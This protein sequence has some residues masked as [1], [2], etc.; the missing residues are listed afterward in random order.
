MMQEMRC[1]GFTATDV[2]MKE[3]TEHPSASHLIHQAAFLQVPHHQPSV[4]SG[5]D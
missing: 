2:R 4:L 3:E 5:S 1:E